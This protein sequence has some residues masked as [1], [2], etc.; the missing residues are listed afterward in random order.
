MKRIMVVL[1]ASFVAFTLTACSPS[2][3]PD[4][5]SG[6]DD[7]SVPGDTSEVVIDA[8]APELLTMLVSEQGDWLW[9]NDYEMTIAETT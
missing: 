9:D 4:N 1:L 5:P 2:G 6:V 8:V 3:A 7:P